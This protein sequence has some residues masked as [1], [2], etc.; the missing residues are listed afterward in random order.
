MGRPVAWLNLTACVRAALLF[1]S[2]LG[3]FAKGI[4]RRDKEMPL[5][6]VKGGGGDMLWGEVTWALGH[7]IYSFEFNFWSK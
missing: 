6:V 4:Q 2:H 5:F 1:V 3:S 7:V